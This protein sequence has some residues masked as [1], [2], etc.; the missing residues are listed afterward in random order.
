MGNRCVEVDVIRLEV[1]TRKLQ[2]QLELAK[3]ELELKRYEPHIIKLLHE[4]SGLIREHKAKMAEMKLNL[5][6]LECDIHK[7][8]GRRFSTFDRILIAAL[9]CILSF[10]Y[11]CILRKTLNHW[12]TR[13]ASP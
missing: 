3:V 6:K 12:L 2:G 1:E 5:M 13:K 4:E 8:R 10:S 7:D 9:T 11:A